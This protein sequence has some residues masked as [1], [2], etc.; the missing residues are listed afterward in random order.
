M[1]IL[2]N[3]LPA[4]QVWQG[5]RGELYLVVGKTVLLSGARGEDGESGSWGLQ[6]H[7]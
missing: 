4:F 1:E 6:C 5:R 7:L 2:S 3:S